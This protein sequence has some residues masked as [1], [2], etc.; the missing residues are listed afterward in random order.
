M[1]P[2]K[3]GSRSPSQRE[4]WAQAQEGG[5]RLMS[6]VYP[7][8]GGC[9]DEHGVRTGT[10]SGYQV[11]P[12]V[13][14]VIDG[15]ENGVRPLAYIDRKQQVDALVT[16]F[17]MPGMNDLDLIREVHKR[18]PR[19]P[20]ILLMGHVGDMIAAPV[21]HPVGEGVIVLQKPIRPAEF[22]ARL[23]VA[24]TEAAR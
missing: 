11:A 9:S 2:D 15:A 18:R 6:Q 5:Y 7:L 8:Q 4:I 13:D 12:G 14:V 16:D 10:R 20:A 1:S 3:A 23:S 17:A 19:L 22:A 24:M 21:D